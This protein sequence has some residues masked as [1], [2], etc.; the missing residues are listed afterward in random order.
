[1]ETNRI[2]KGDIVEI[3]PG[4]RI[5]SKHTAEHY[6]PSMIGKVTNVFDSGVNA[7][8]RAIEEE[9]DAHSCVWIIKVSALEVIARKDAI[10]ICQ[11]IW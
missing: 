11:S 2:L 7:T 1:M 10:G 4:T 6:F 9:S 8:V 3:S 5:T